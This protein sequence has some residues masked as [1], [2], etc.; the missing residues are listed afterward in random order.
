LLGLDIGDELLHL[1]LSL[2]VAQAPVSAP[3]RRY[4]EQLEKILEQ[5][6]AGSRAEALAQPSEEF[7]KT[8][9]ALPPSDAVK[10]A[11][12]AVLQLQSSWRAWCRQQEQSHGLA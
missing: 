9:Y 8:L 3:Q 2:A 10:L 7:L 4:L 12:G 1:R 11:Q 5:G 6:P